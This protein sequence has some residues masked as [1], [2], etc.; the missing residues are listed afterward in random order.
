MY[1]VVRWIPLVKPEQPRPQ[2]HEVS[3]K[4][5]MLLGECSATLVVTDADLLKLEKKAVPQGSK[6]IP[7]TTSGRIC[8]HSQRLLTCT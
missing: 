2:M 8:T 6:R 4:Y 5:I 7:L 1:H 3:R